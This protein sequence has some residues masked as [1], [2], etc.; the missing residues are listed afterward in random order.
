MKFFFFLKIVHYM[1]SLLLLIPNNKGLAFK[2]LCASRII[3][4]D[5]CV[6]V[7][8]WC[9]SNL[10]NINLQL[11]GGGR[12]WGSYVRLLIA[13]VYVYYIGEAIDAL[14][15]HIC[16]WE[17]I[18]LSPRLLRIYYKHNWFSK[19][20]DVIAQWLLFHTIYLIYY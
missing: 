16:L 20:R 13:K 19:R 14:I 8:P 5:A 6:C 2:C 4:W 7:C 12:W 11:L 18:S 1:E 3:V 9:R 10:I 17:N 15:W